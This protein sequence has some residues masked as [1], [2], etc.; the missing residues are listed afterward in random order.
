[1]IIVFSL[2]SP[3]LLVVKNGTICWE[4]HRQM[5]S[6]ESPQMRHGEFQPGWKFAKATSTWKQGFV[7]ESRILSH[8]TEDTATAMRSGNSYSLFMPGAV[9][10]VYLIQTSV[11]QNQEMYFH[12]QPSK[13]GNICGQ[14]RYRE[15]KMKNIF[16]PHHCWTNSAR[17]RHPGEGLGKPRGGAE[18]HL[19]PGS[20]LTSLIWLDLL[21]QLFSCLI[22]QGAGDI[23]A[24]ADF[25]L[26]NL[27]FVSTFKRP[28][29]Y[30][31]D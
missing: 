16:L 24:D 23:C 20:I 13:P 27:Y 25:N 31:Y 30:L 17:W 5:Y 18:P 14:V 19:T 22:P 29:D 21:L 28:A 11:A 26:F 4:Y 3:G 12:D 10:W 7:M 1:M 2:Y 8:I 15:G 9:F 6:A